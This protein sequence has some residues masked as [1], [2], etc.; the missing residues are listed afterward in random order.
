MKSVSRKKD[1][2][3]ASL[4]CI[5][6]TV[7][8]KNFWIR[9]IVQTCSTISLYLKR[10]FYLIL[11]R[12]WHNNQSALKIVRYYSYKAKAAEK[13]PE[14]IKKVE[15]IFQK[16]SLLKKD[17]QLK[18]KGL[19]L[20]L[21]QASQANEAGGTTLKFPR[22]KKMPTI[23]ARELFHIHGNAFGANNN[24]LE[25]STLQTTLSYLQLFFTKRQSQGLPCYGLTEDH[26]RQ[27][28][29]AVELARDF[30]KHSLAKITTA[31]EHQKR[32]LLP[33]GWTGL[34]A[35]HAMCYEI[36]PTS[37]QQATVRVF[38]LGAGSEKHFRALVGN[39]VKTLPYVDFVGVS[40]EALTDPHTLQALYE[41]LTYALLPEDE[42]QKTKYG[43]ED[44][45]TGIIS[46]L[47]PDKMNYPENPPALD[48]LKTPQRAGVCSMRSPLVFLST[49]MPK[50]A[51][52]QFICDLRMQSLCD[53]ISQ[54][55]DRALTNANWRLL[56]K[57][58]TNLSKRIAKNLKNSIL[59]EQYAL[60]SAAKLTKISHFL[61][62]KRDQALCSQTASAND[63]PGFEIRS[64]HL[65]KDLSTPLHLLAN[66]QNKPVSQSYSFVFHAVNQLDSKDLTRSLPVLIQLAEEAKGR[67][68]Y[69]ALHH[70][71]IHFFSKIPVLDTYQLTETEYKQL[72]THLGKISETF[73]ETCF[74]V[75]NPERIHPERLNVLL[76]ILYMQKRLIGFE[77][78]LDLGCLRSSSP[79]DS[80]L[81]PFFFKILDFEL[82][83]EFYNTLSFFDSSA[84]EH[85]WGKMR[86]DFYPNGAFT[87]QLPKLFPEIS[88]ELAK[89][90]A[91][92]LCLNE[93]GQAA[94]IYASDKLPEWFK[95]FRNTHLYFLYLSHGEAIN[96]PT[97]KLDCSISF[98]LTHSSHESIVKFSIKGI[99]EDKF[100]EPNFQKNKEYFENLVRPIQNP[101][102]KKITDS[103]LTRKYS[104]ESELLSDHVNKHFEGVSDELYKMLRHIHIHPHLQISETLAYFEKN[105]SKLHDPD[106]QVLLEIF[107]FQ[108]KLLAKEIQLQGFVGLL[109]NFLRRNYQ[110]ACDKNAIQ[111]AV[112]ILKMRRLC[113]DYLRDDPIFGYEHPLYAD[114]FDDLKSLLRHENLSVEEK[115]V[116]HAEIV[117]L[118]SRKQDLDQQSIKDLLIGSCYLQR[119]PVPVKWMCPETDKNVLSAIH[120]H[121]YS[122]KEFFLK[123]EKKEIS[124]FLSILLKEVLGME[125]IN[126]WN[127]IRQPGEFPYFESNDGTRILYHPLISR[128][129]IKN[130]ELILPIEI[131]EHV[132]FRQLFGSV[133]RGIQRANGIYELHLT[134]GNPTFIR[135]QNRQL[136]IEQQRHQKWYRFIPQESLRDENGK[137]SF[138]SHHLARNF[139][140]WLPLSDSSQL[141][142]VHPQTGKTTYQ[143]HLSN[144]CINRIFNLE[145]KTALHS[146]SDRVR[147]FENKDYIQ[148]W[149][150]KKWY[151][152]NICTQIELPRFGLNFERY[153]K[154]GKLVCSLFK[155]QGF[156]LAKK[157]YSPF[158]G[159]Y[160]NAL[161]LKNAQGARK[162]VIPYHFFKKQEDD[163]LESLKPKYSLEQNIS[164]A[165]P[166]GQ[167]FFTYDVNK[168]GELKALSKKANFFLAYVLAG[169]G[170]YATAAKYLKKYGTKLSAYTEEEKELLL[171]LTTLGDLIG[172]MDGNAVALRLYAHYLLIKNGADHN[173]PVTKN[174]LSSFPA[175][176]NTY[177]MKYHHATEL[178]L[179]RYEELFVLKYL[180]KQNYDPLQFV[181]LN[182]LDSAYAQTYV[183]PPKENPKNSFCSPHSFKRMFSSKFSKEHKTFDIQTAL[184]TQI[185]VYIQSSFN[186]IYEMARNGS[187]QEKKWLK[188]ALQFYKNE[189]TNWKALIECVINFAEKFTPFEKTQAWWQSMLETADQLAKDA[190][191]SEIAKECPPDIPH[192]TPPDFKLDVELEKISAIHPTYAVPKLPLFKTECEREKCFKQAKIQET[193]DQNLKNWL[194]AEALHPSSPEPLYHQKFAQLSQELKQF[195]PEQPFQYTLDKKG[196]KSIEQILNRGKAEAKEQLQ[197]LKVKIAE[198]AN[199]RSSNAFQKV[200]EQHLLLAGEQKALTLDELMVCFGRKDTASLLKKNPGLDAQVIETLFKLVGEYLAIQTKEQQRQRASALLKQAKACKPSEEKKEL[201][202]QLATALLETRQYNP[203]AHPAYLVFEYYANICLRQ[204]Q[205]QKLA[206]FLEA[207]D[208]NPIMEMIMGSG[209]SK[210]LLPLLSLLRADRNTL[211][212]LIV[213]TPL[214]KSVA[215]DTQTILSETFAMPLRALHFDRSTTFSVHSLQTILDDLRRVQKER[216]CLIMTSKSLECFILKFMERCHYFIPKGEFPEELKIMAEILSLLAT[217]SHPLI[218]EADTVLNV[219]HEVCFSIGEKQAHNKDAIVTISLLLELLFTD[220]E[221]KALGQLDSDPQPDSQAPIFTEEL[222]HQ[223]IKALLAEKFVERLENTLFDT[224][225]TTHNIQNFLKSLDR[226]QKNLVLAYLCREPSHIFSA[227]NFYDAQQDDVKNILALAAE[228][229]SSFLPH[230]LS[231]GINKKY[232]LDLE[233][234]SSIAIP[235][236]AANTPS[237]G[238]Q[239]ANPF[240]TMNYT[241]QYYAKENVSE[242]I[243]MQEIERLQIKAMHEMKDSPHLTLEKTDAW[244]TFCKIRGPLTTPLFNLNQLHI[245]QLTQHVNAS[246]PQK[247]TFVMHAILPQ[248]EI[249]SHKISCNPHNLIGLFKKNL[250]GFTGTLWNSQSMHSKLNPEAEVGTDIKTIKLLH[251]HSLNEVYVI[252]EGSTAE[253]LAE[254]ERQKIKFDLMSDAGGYFK[255][256]GNAAIAKTLARKNG[257]PVVFYNRK[258][259]QVETDGEREIPL[260]ESKTSLDKRQTFLDQSHTTG[261]DV[262]QKMGAIGIVTL[263]QNM[264]LR[265]LLQAAWRLRGLENKAQRVKFVLTEEVESIIQQKLQI[266]HKPTFCDILRFTILN[267]AKQQGNDNFKALRQEL[268][269]AFQSI[270]LDALID[271]TY[272][273]EEKKLLFNY[274]QKTWIQEDNAPPKNLYGTISREE[275]STLVR[276][277]VERDYL[278]KIQTL[279][280]NFPFLEQKGLSC[281][282]IETSIK[283]I[284]KKHQHSLAAKV[285][286]PIRSIDSDQT[287]E[288]E[289]ETEIENELEVQAQKEREN[290]QLGRIESF[291]GIFP[292]KMLELHF[293]AIPGD[294]LS[295]RTPIPR[296]YMAPYFEMKDYCPYDP[297]LK[298]YAEA[299]EGISISINAIEWY[300]VHPA[301]KD[302]KLLGNHRVPFHYVQVI[303]GQAVILSQDDVRDEKNEKNNLYRLGLGYYDQSR[304]VPKD[305]LKK[306]VKIE[307]LNGESSYSEEKQKILR[308]WFA[309]QGVEKMQMLFQKHI[310][311]GF[312]D[313]TAAYAHSHLQKIFRE[314]SS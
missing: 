212:T 81:Q 197:R 47:K 190:L 3:N 137:S 183:I 160:K 198:I 234:Q 96:P 82:Q 207:G 28:A 166:S 244:K 32:L 245:Q 205:V 89:E 86:L 38:N 133:K 44:I 217:N 184:I 10:I 57:S 103:F 40:K 139:Q 79:K 291:L 107:F 14:K 203:N 84:V 108:G 1:H 67:Q 296:P 271:M 41:L 261:A 70:A 119:Y 22:I 272:S 304:P 286:V 287:A 169:V 78:N 284:C 253:M 211:S 35:G 76:K 268:E 227:Q 267:Q 75:P 150:S 156:Y 188:V 92:F 9:P 23:T 43:T 263:D 95:S 309:E 153:L 201:T 232:G 185:N 97:D 220:P 229:V 93:I 129:Y 128:F 72:L 165:L 307:F 237:K 281:E 298:D 302:F 301:I 269:Q 52:K 226:T 163:K 265:D 277:T 208:L 311:A 73:F 61:K 235:Y 147:H 186:Q 179:N 31:F 136:I 138:F 215:T 210:V 126:N 187:L 135:L 200:L 310:L 21:L 104:K 143:A 251:Q 248:L 259:E 48:L 174:A 209:K 191:N 246:I 46:L 141:D 216:E 60:S 312:P 91:Q 19:N 297:I 51:Y 192:L 101:E 157:Q 314:M 49:C 39:K 90:N 5:A 63:N 29:D 121:A 102:L 66:E 37:Y 294:V 77:G 130:E 236:S 12:E 26:L 100:Q 255:E 249:F 24:S 299:F 140:H 146:P 27:L 243:I 225:S 11:Y 2:L 206:K 114:T 170:E 285:L 199:T 65:P 250:S 113:Q 168:E 283:Q 290:I 257:N 260:N 20:S 125:E 109:G 292:L 231:K 241:F 118:L 54:V 148:E 273:E 270:L 4:N 196:I 219:L 256:G 16:L 115:S 177:L 87:N 223:K 247:N 99:S 71:L 116:I 122:I 288:R 176:Y 80:L 50:K 240:I 182:E 145:Q 300:E 36:I 25:G 204:A 175:C 252:K 74:R 305:L 172:D 162:V 289:Q 45:Y 258:N 159:A 111:T 193:G 7:K 230:T 279:F 308:E 132:H 6:P 33:G 276:Q 313:K 173:Q 282:V 94:C 158:L 180:L 181:R 152:K 106:Y 161:I 127:A 144:D 280:S 18:L 221:L 68:E 112:F 275:D 194:E 58:Q 224:N 42:S 189:K 110:S 34:P 123:K 195:K 117:S 62:G 69:L 98:D 88:K 178:K 53:Y 293:S 242:A 83:R 214:F 105:P 306:I 218:D 8:N 262:P 55:Q 15:A 124:A 239:F 59:D 131:R 13:T 213:P 233:S 238:S 264:L 171:H 303:E 151:S 30:K 155:E 278:E 134:N 64:V 274:L 228:E 85:C 202:Q 56:E 17:K 120:I 149:Y 154:T 266:A 295:S 254:L 222:Y 164:N 142:L 167:K